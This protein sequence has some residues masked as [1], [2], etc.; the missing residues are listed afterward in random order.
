MKNCPEFN[1]NIKQLRSS[2]VHERNYK[3]CHGFAL[4]FALTTHSAS[5]KMRAKPRDRTG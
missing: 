3:Y 5:S 2:S 1:F 4:N